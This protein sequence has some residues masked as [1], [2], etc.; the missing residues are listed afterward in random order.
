MWRIYAPSKNGVKIQTTITNLYNSLYRSTSEYPRMSCYIGKVDYQS[1]NKLTALAKEVRSSGTSMGGSY[2]QAKSLLIKRFAFKHEEEVRLIYLDP[3]NQ[4]EDNIHP[5]RFDP[6][7]HVQA[8][9]FD[10]RMGESLYRVYKK[11]IEGLGFTGK[12][13][14]SGLYKEMK[15][16]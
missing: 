10:P 3:R 16:L 11:H 8:M 9:T 12:I 15:L 14:Q 4:T 2:Y 6:L 5:Y 1:K 7:L 13:I